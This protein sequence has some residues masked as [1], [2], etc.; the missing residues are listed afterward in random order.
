MSGQLAAKSLDGYGKAV[1]SRSKTMKG[2]Q[3][4]IPYARQWPQ[5]GGDHGR[6]WPEFAG[7]GLDTWTVRNRVQ[8]RFIIG[9]WVSESAL[10]R[11]LGRSP[12]RDRSLIEQG[13]EDYNQP[14]PHSSL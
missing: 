12:Q 11:E 8:L 13:R 6:Q 10:V 14:R 1:K 2:G 9:G 5:A 3:A 4:T 7:K